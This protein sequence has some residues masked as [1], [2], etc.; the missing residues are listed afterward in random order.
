M[1]TNE[2]KNKILKDIYYDL[3]NPAAFSSPYNL[4]KA[5]KKKKITLREVKDFLAGQDAY[6]L[7]VQA[8]KP[9]KF[10][11]TIA[12]GINEIHQADLI[13]MSSLSK[14]NKGYKFILTNIDVFSRKAWAIPIKNKMAISVKN[15]F[16]EIHKLAK[17]KFLNTD[18]GSEFLASVTQNYF[19]SK[20]IRHYTTSSDYKASLCERFNRTL[21]SMIYKYFT[22][23]NTLKY[24]DVLEDIVSS[25]NNRKHSSIGIAPNK[26]NSKN[27][28]K[29]W[30]Y[31]Y[32]EE[33]K[34]SKNPFKFKIGDFVR[35][36]KMNKTFGKKYLPTFTKEV[37]VVV[38]KIRTNPPTYRVMD[39]SKQIIHGSFYSSEL[40][41]VISENDK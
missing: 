14:E 24:T 11:K 39:K 21:Q 15:A 20:E 36:V 40:T 16:Q 8:K 37:F 10:R 3:K 19:K 28:K 31:Q 2:N 33:T 25:Y 32:G 38:N 13:D 1:T 17:P 27:T 23:S 7:H 22:S 5:V 41:R 9:R 26:V 34:Q 35:L 12:H 30:N 18:K 4:Y 29:I 6:T